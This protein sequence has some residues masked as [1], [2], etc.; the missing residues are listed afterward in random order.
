MFLLLHNKL[1]VV[2]RLFRIRLRNDPYCQSCIGAEVAD[3][4]HF[5]C[6]CEKVRRVWGWVKLEVTKHMG[7]QQDVTDW[8]LL[9]MFF[10]SSAYDQEN[11]W[12]ISSYVLFVWENGVRDA[13]VK[14]EQFFGFLTYKYR[15]H[16]AWSRTQL[17][18]IDGI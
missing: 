10:P 6:L 14:L 5:F 15:E 13:E 12:L 2:E 8:S 7:H 3:V 11:V 18:Q 16:Q 9:N 17:K 1:P 4:E